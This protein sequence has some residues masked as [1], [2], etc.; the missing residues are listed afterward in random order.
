MTPHILAQTEQI[1]RRAEQPCCVQT[2][3]GRKE[4]LLLTQLLRQTGQHPSLYD[5][6]SGQNRAAPNFNRFQTGFA[7]D[8]A[9]AGGIEVAFQ[10]RQLRQRGQVQPHIDDIVALLRVHRRVYT[11]GDVADQIALGHHSFAVQ[12]TGG[13]L[14]VGP[15]RA[16]CDG[17]GFGLPTRLQA[18][19]QRLFRGQII[20]PFAGAALL[21]NRHP[22]AHFAAHTHGHLSLPRLAGVT[23]RP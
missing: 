11:V 7:A 20:Q 23:A 14:K 4:C 10:R 13:Q 16:H 21:H 22:S 6:A 15:R 2:T 17:D 9:G 3:R 18:D 1:T 19:F 8:T 12:K 5:R